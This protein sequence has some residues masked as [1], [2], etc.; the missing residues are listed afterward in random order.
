[1]YG[2][3]TAARNMMYCPQTRKMRFLCAAKRLNE[4]C[5]QQ[6]LCRERFKGLYA[7]RLIEESVN[8]NRPTGSR[9]EAESALCKVRGSQR[10]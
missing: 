3:L 9:S 6:P 7:Y 5:P 1:M 8:L 4:A 2:T 10:R